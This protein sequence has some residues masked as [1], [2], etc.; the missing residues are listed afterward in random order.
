MLQEEI[1]KYSP[2]H[3]FVAGMDTYFLTSF[4]WSLCVLLPYWGEIFPCLRNLRAMAVLIED[5]LKLS[6]GGKLT[7]LKHGGLELYRLDL[8]PSL[9]FSAV[10]ETWV[11]SLSQEDPPGEGHSNPFQSS[12]LENSMDRGAWRATVYG[13]T[14]SWTRLSDEHTL[15]SSLQ[16]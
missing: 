10:Q 14:K 7:I 12:C 13:V 3:F 15:H 5:A 6:R 11:Q 16:T 2:E 1:Q 9:H 8:T 4:W